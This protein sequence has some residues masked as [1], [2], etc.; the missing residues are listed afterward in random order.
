MAGLGKGRVGRVTLVQRN[1]S[2]VLRWRQLRRQCW[3]RIGPVENEN[4]L[5]RAL[6]RAAEVNRD[7]QNQGALAPKFLPAS[8]RTAC[9]TYLL[10]KEAAPSVSGATIRKYR[11]EMARILLFAEGTPAGRRIRHV[12]LLDS[13]WCEDFCRWLDGLATTRNGLS[14]RQGATQSPLSA[15][16]KQGIRQRLWSVLEHARLR[17]P[18]FTPFDFRNPMSEELIGFRRRPA[19][20]ISSPPTTDEELAR[21]VS[22]LD[23]YAL[24]LLAPLF[25]YGPRPSEL[26]HILR[27]DYD[28]AAGCIKVLS[29][30]SAGYQTKGRRDKVWPVTATLHA[31]LRPLLTLATGTLF[32]K[33]RL[34]AGQAAPL[35]PKAAETDLVRAFEERR[36]ALTIASK[37]RPGKTELDRIAQQTWAAAGA[38]ETRDLLRELRRAARTAGLAKSPTP[39]DIRHLVESECEAARLSPGVIRHLLGHAPA[40]GDALIHY[41]HTGLAVLR[42]QVA[43]LEGRRRALVDALTE[44][45][46]ALADRT[47]E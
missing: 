23:P 44:R 25:L 35:L 36:Q 11:A 9:D 45:T 32:P 34:F 24:A 6:A 20:G 39:K 42:E 2:L 14:P 28:A 10:A 43:L 17:N 18:P 12:H 13:R 21:I 22:V 33:R 47:T 1:R 38:V 27:S 5:A 30:P 15:R 26:G 4:T 8:P 31:C 40:R 3:E 16:L 19:S 29:R 46:T 7:L 41:N 37:N